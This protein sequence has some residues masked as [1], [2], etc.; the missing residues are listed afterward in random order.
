MFCRSL[1]VFL[2]F[3]I[4]PLCFL[5]FFDLRILITSLWYL[6]TLLIL[7]ITCIMW[8]YFYFASQCILYQL[9]MYKSGAI[10]DFKLGGAHLKKL[11]R[12]E[13]GA[14]IFGVFRVK[15]HDFTPK[16]IIFFP[17]LG[18]GAPWIRPC[19]STTCLMWS[20]FT[21]TL[22]NYIRL[23]WLRFYYQIFHIASG[24][25]Y[26]IFGKPRNIFVHIPIQDH[27]FPTPDVVVIFAFTSWRWEMVGI[28]LLLV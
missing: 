16:K 28:A 10:Q 5:F 22:G 27:G 1:F 11:R 9:N 12:A 13:G 4:W 8:L 26:H 6:Q 20:Y 17:I 3:F 2:Y 18:G 14:K 19:K 25:L 7:E 15:N 24:S 23:V 21:V